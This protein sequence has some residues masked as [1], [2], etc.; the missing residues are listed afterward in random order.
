MNGK[1]NVNIMNSR[2]LSFVVGY[3]KL[4]DYNYNYRN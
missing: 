4:M 1:G 2:M 3:K